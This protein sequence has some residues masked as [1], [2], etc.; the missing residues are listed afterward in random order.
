MRIRNERMIETEVCTKK[1]GKE[2]TDDLKDLKLAQWKCL[3]WK[4]R[5]TQN[6]LSNVCS[7]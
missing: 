3:K 5:N 1:R 4:Q 6:N 2:D 7:G